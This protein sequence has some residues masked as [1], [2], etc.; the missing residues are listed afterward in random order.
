MVFL[1]NYNEL[2]GGVVKRKSIAVQIAMYIGTLAIVLCLAI[3]GISIWSSFTAMESQAKRA[4]QDITE[5]G[6]E[7][8]SILVEDR[9]ALLQEIANRTR[10]QSMNFDVQKQSLQNDVKR[11]GYL[12]MAIVTPDGQARYILEDKTADLSDRGYVKA[13]LAGTGNMSDVIISKVTNSAV[14]M[15]AV[16]IYNGDKVVGALV[17]R[18]DGNALFEI[19]DKMGYGEN[20]YAYIINDK[21][22]VVAHPNRDLVMQQFAPIEA[23]KQNPEYQS[24]SEIFTFMLAQ[25]E[26]VGGY[27]FN[28]KDL[29]NGFTPIRGTSWLLINTAV[30]SEVMAAVNA[31]V[32]KMI[33]TVAVALAVALLLSYLLGKQI[34]KPIEKLTK[35]VNTFADLNFRADNMPEKFTKKRANEIDLMAIAVGHMAENIREFILNVSDTAEQVSATSQ[36]LSAT[37][38]ESAAVS[39]EVAHAVGKIASGANEQSESTGQATLALNVLSREIEENNVRA[40]DLTKSSDKIKNHITDGLEVVKRLEIKND[41]NKTAMESGYQ[42]VLRTNN[43]T[44]KINEVTG[45]IASVSEQTNLLAL[46]ASIEA[47]RA[48]EH[49]RGFAVVAEEIRKLAEQSSSMTEMIRKTVLDLSA[50]VNSVVEEMTKTN[51][52]VSEQ[53]ISVEETRTA[54]NHIADAIVDSGTFVSLIDSSSQ[55][56]EMHKDEVLS[57]LS[58]LS[59]VAEDNAASAEEVSAAAE[60]QSASAVEIS[61]ASEDLSGMA[62]NL[63]MLISKFKV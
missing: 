55:T 37:S 54:F 2:R 49:G 20:G 5:Q 16:P 6:S 43:S 8:I 38:Q 14:L 40:K 22:V 61:K 56:M 17:A 4:L 18:R 15:F 3:G 57:T 13:A 1:F 46:N 30:K 48:G 42:S 45:M 9:I 27:R 51:T 32:H 10:T 50:D 63:Q 21:G 28:G 23:A 59:S 25:K 33:V 26:G 58:G 47:A 36:E 62:Q 7:K 53:A 29:I 60:E 44:S 34:A 52:I 19:I 31:L 39:E 24:A 35:S 12:D 11:L 41:Q